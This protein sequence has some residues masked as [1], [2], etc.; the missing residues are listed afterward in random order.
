MTTASDLWHSAP[1][2]AVERN[3]RVES[4]HAG[5]V[6]LCDT[7]GQVVW[8]VGSPQRPTY[9][10]SS[11][12]PLQALTG[13]TLG[14]ADRYG[15]TDAELAV[16][17]ASHTAEPVHRLAVR[18]ILAKAGLST[19]DLQCGPH[20]PLD[21]A[22]RH[23]LLRTGRRPTRIHSN[24]SGKHAGMLATCRHADWPTSTYRDPTHPLQ[25]AIAELV[26]R[27]GDLPG[28]IPVGVDGCGVPT[29]FA[30]L[31][32]LATALARLGRPTSLPAGLPDSAPR[33]AE[34]IG[35]AIVANPVLLS[36][37]GRFDTRI[38]AFAGGQVLA[39]GG[40]EGVFAAA[41][42]G[43]GLGFALKI[44]DGEA[45]AIPA[46][47]TAVLAALLP[48]LLSPDG[49]ES[50]DVFRNRVAPPIRNTRGEVVGRFVPLASPD[51]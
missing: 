25:Q 40:A 39:K 9:W 16:A 22:T 7:T 15:W 13:L 48:D 43:Q 17:C 30:P 10:R 29:F 33:H 18:A 47:A 24:C 5:Q 4:V 44:D 27:M 21:T 31:Q 41:L 50:W 14:V 6:V 35:R 11:A 51:A 28:A 2:V 3:G 42:P 46:L 1:L 34:R 19:A 23:E 8:S 12:K 32:A 36:G 26:G 45:R 38:V 49:S 20:P 37:Q